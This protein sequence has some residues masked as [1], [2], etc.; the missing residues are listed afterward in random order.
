[1]TPTITSG[2]RAKLQTLY[3]QYARRSLDASPTREGRLLWAT[4]RTGRPISSFSDLSL[5]EATQLIDGLNCALG[6]TGGPKRRPRLDRRAAE[7]A[8][9]QGRYDQAHPE[10]TLVSP[11]DQARIRYVMG[12]LDWTEETLQRWLQSGRSPLRG[13]AEIRTLSDANKVFWALKG[14]ATH[15]GVWKDSKAYR[16]E[17]RSA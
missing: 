17:R 5:A 15:K 3:A 7:N 8:G 9:T 1:M 14:M 16:Q 13:R 2:Q 6:V 10:S 11:A 4:E 12:L